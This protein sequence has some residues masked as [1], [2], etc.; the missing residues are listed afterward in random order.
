MKRQIQ[1]IA[2]LMLFGLQDAH[3][4]A[5]DLFLSIDRQGMEN[6][7]MNSVGVSRNVI[8]NNDINDKKPKTV[9]D[10]VA[11]VPGIYSTKRASLGF[12]IGPGGAGGISIRGSSTEQRTIIAVDGRSDMM[13]IFGHPLNDA[14][15]IETAEKVE[16]VR[17]PDSVRY[18]S[19]ALGGS[20]NYISKKRHEEGVETGIELSGGSFG[21]RTG[22]L[23]HG[24]KFGNLDYYLVGSNRHTDGFR[25]NSSADAYQIYSRLGYEWTKNLEAEIAVRHN[26]TEILDPGTYTEVAAMKRRNAGFDKWSRLM[27]SGVDLTVHEAVGP[28]EGTVKG[29]IGY[30]NNVIRQRTTSTYLWD[31][32]DRTYGVIVSQRAK[33][34]ESTDI[35]LGYD[36]KQNGGEG[37][38]IG[39]RDYPNRNI[40]EQGVFTNI[41]QTI[42][43]KI[44]GSI[45]ARAHH[46]ESFG[47]EFISSLGLEYSLLPTTILK[48]SVSKGFRSPTITEL[49]NAV[50]QG[51]SE[52]FP[53]RAWNYEVG[54][55][56][57]FGEKVSMDITGYY[58]GGDNLIRA[59]G[60]SPA[61]KYRNTGKFVHR[62][63]EGNLKV[64]ALSFLDLV[65]GLTLADHGDETRA[66]PEQRYTLSVQC[67]VQKVF[68]EVSLEKV[69]KLYGADYKVSRLPNYA[70]INARANYQ[71]TKNVKIFAEVENFFN[72]YYE[73]VAGYP[74]PGINGLGGVEISF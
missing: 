56:Q 12:G 70:I 20:I 61:L 41:K 49:F 6:Q 73:I 31:S 36:I 23:K 7:S 65:G 60:V 18:G 63:I 55:S 62:G 24:A 66:N 74:M 10:A 42:L 47:W 1:V 37:H 22:I 69:E 3:L 32:I 15:T 4:F 5:K 38:D 8:N 57:G 44:V 11:S 34:T 40:V 27:R 9:N 48:S 64:H 46:H 28:T 25:D 16:V 17:G 30:G 14:Y 13:G 35:E 29:Y 19:G 50:P 72:E 54:V 67:H 53:E 51:N 45:G 58:L 39:V 26:D 33:P 52:L 43:E 68:G 21:T 2:I 59:E 71:L